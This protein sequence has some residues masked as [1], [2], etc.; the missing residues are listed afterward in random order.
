MASHWV[1]FTFPGIIEEPGSFAGKTTSPIPERG[2]LANQRRSLAILNKD[3]ATVFSALDSSTMLSWPPSASNLFSAV[4]K[5]RSVSLDISAAAFSPN[6]SM[7]LIPVPTAVPP[8]A[9]S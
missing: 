1:G 2:P 6:P 5:G 4:R 3:T 9:N 8:M 7:E